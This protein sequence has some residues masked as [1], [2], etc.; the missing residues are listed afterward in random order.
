MDLCLVFAKDAKEVLS[1]AKLSQRESIRCM[2][3]N[4]DNVSASRCL[5]A[6]QL[7]PLVRSWQR[8]NR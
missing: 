8:V 7:I 4:K 5:T 1:C 3:N 2:G 6:P